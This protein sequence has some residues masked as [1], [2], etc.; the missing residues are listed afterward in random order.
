MLESPSVG[1]GIRHVADCLK[2]YLSRPD[3]QPMTLIEYADRLGNGAVFKR[4]GF[5]VERLNGPKSLVDACS[6]RLTKGVAKLDPH[7]PSN[8]LLR[9]WR[10]LSPALLSYGSAAG[11]LGLQVA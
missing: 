5:L 9:R 1:G 8:R 3:A 7:L 11:Y 2:V 4:L 10:A 6:Q